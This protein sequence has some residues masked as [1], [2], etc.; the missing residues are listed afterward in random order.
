M[1][2]NILTEEIILSETY[3]QLISHC[4][5]LECRTSLCTCIQEIKALSS[6]TRINVTVANS[7]IGWS[8][9][10]RIQK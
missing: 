7:D 2:T 10:T 1:G 3:Y 4:P 5:I 8:T 6:E 9:L